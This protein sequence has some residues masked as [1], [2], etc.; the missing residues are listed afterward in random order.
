M[1]SFLRCGVSVD[2]FLRKLKALHVIIM[3]F[4]IV[5]FLVRLRVFLDMILF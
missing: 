1:I 2:L 4:A 5:S 3:Y